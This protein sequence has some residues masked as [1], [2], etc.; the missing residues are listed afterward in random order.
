MTDLPHGWEWATLEDLLAA[1][2]RAITDGPFGSNLAS[3]HYTQAGA[4][5]IRL[6]NI[7]D[8]VFNDERAYI[9]LD[10]FEALRAHEVREGDIV[11]ASLGEQLPRAC[12]VPKPDGPAIVKADCIRARPHPAIDRHWLLYML[13]A[14]AT[15][16]Y[17]TSKIRGVGRPRLG[18][19]EIRRIPLP[20]PPTAEQRRIV[21]VIDEYLSRL[22]FCGPVVRLAA[23]SARKLW[24]STLNEVATVGLLDRK[25][26][27][28]EVPMGQ[29]ADIS[30][31]IQKQPKRAPKK[32]AYPFLR[33]ANINRGRLD[34]TDVHR[35]E[36]FPGELDR[37]RI[38]KDDLLVVEGNGSSSEIGRAARWGGEITDCVHQNHLIRVRP[39]PTL[40]SRFLEYSWNSPLI[41]SRLRAIASS[42]SGLYTLSTSKI[43]SLLLPVPPLHAQREAVE[44][45]DLIR[46]RL[47]SADK[48]LG[49][50][51]Q[52]SDKIRKLLLAKAFAG[53]LV[54]QDPGD[55]PASVLL[56][57]I[58]AERAA[59][60][61]VPRGRRRSVA[62][63]ATAATSATDESPS[64]SSG[65]P[66]ASNESQG[67]LL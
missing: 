15:R 34:L 38:Q 60:G 31:G 18:L 26:F 13:I 21:A 52:R 42:T 5:V 39:G 14:P 9:S 35:V 32:N 66:S 2:P 49:I 46:S 19:G 37:F 23:S 51:Y 16:A 43:R 45:A 36:L 28:E 47:E 8:G 10:H 30:G 57:R 53:R 6:Q 3:R 61:S 65:S 17:A 48:S 64:A 40:D 12:L 24:E 20:V 25:N 55:E 11:I 58:R 59:V 33:V 67:V 29:L 50:A 44:K 27:I 7:G 56:E 22:D 41:A 54:P 63:T 1:E 4:Q 62:N